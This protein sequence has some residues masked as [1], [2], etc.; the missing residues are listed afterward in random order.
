MKDKTITIKGAD[1]SDL[2]LDARTAAIIV[3]CWA[4][5]RAAG[6]ASGDLLSDPEFRLDR[7]TFN[8]LLLGRWNVQ[9]LLHRA[10]HEN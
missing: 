3:G 6:T 7:R 1:G 9:S 8:T 2:E 5:G 4:V 10:L